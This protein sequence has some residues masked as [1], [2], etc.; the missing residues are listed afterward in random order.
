MLT[1]WTSVFF[2]QL[3]DRIEAKS[4]IQRQSPDVKL[5]IYLLPAHLGCLVG[6]IYDFMSDYSAH[7]VSR[8][9]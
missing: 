5:M 9:D 2:I 6:L 8:F 4:L 7:A 3:L 1:I